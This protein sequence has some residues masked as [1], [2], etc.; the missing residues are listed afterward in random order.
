ML[1]FK[2]KFNGFTVRKAVDKTT[3]VINRN[4][5]INAYNSKKCHWQK[6]CHYVILKLQTEDARSIVAVISI[7]HCYTQHYRALHYRILDNSVRFF[8]TW[9]IIILHKWVNFIGLPAAPHS[10]CAKLLYQP[11]Y[12]SY[13]KCSSAL[14]E[15]GSA[16]I[17]TTSPD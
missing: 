3:I 13:S 12:G 9:I 1:D 5:K 4:D 15:C 7:R 2:K 6:C 8:S 11:S 16:R 10:G 17:Q 14:Y